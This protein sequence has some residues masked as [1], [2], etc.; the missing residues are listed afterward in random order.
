MSSPDP[1]VCSPSRRPVLVPADVEVDQPFDANGLYVLRAT[2]AAHASRLGAAQEHVEHL[3]IVAVELAT[4]A[5]RHGGGTG[6]IRLWQR[7]SVLYCQVA[8]RGPG[9]ADSTVGSTAPDPARL[10]G[11]RGM[12]ICRNLAS[13]LTIHTG[14]GGQ[15]TTITAAI[16]PIR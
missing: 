13:E 14:N 3:L 8:D 6:R 15:G 2:L 12:W 9:I 4:N 16:S 5:I 1:P 11:G 7:D 10:D